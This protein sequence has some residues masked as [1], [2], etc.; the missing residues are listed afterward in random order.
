[1]SKETEPLKILTVS[2]LLAYE[3]PDASKIVI[4]QERGTCTLNFD[5]PYEVDLDRIKS[6]RDLLAWVRLLADKPWMNGERTK[7]FIDAVAKQKGFQVR[8]P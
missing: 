8:M 1:M 2:E 4:D 6:E 7:L 3:N 5:Y